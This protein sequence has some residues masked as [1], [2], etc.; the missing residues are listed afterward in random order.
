MDV[1]A[2][3][4]SALTRA[5]RVLAYLLRSNDKSRSQSHPDMKNLFALPVIIALAI[6]C[7]C[8]KQPT[9]QEIQARIEQEVQRRL[10][11]EHEAQEQ[12]RERRR[13][14]FTARRNAL[15]E[16]RGAATNTLVPGVPGVPSR[17]SIRERSAN[18]ATASSPGTVPIPRLPPGLPERPFPRRRFATPM[19]APSVPGSSEISAT[20]SVTPAYSASPAFSPL[21]EAPESASPTITPASP[22]GTAQ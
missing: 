22:E 19:P 7:S 6:F 2:A 10:A 20:P 21:T 13:A 17:P 12:E 18:A 15:L 11:A 9:E 14:E 16:R 8:Q 4:W 5:G 1:A 3:G